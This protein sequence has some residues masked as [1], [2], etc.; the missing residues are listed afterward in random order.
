MVTENQYLFKKTKIIC[1]IG[2]SS[3][4][5]RTILSMIQK[6]MNVAR[7]NASH[8][9]HP[10]LAQWIKTIRK[11]EKEALVPIPILLDL[12]GPKIRMGEMEDGKPVGLHSGQE[13]VITTETV[14]GNEKRISTTYKSLPK[15]VNPGDILFLNDGLVRLKVKEKTSKEIHAVIE[16]GGVIS[17]FKGINIPGG[18]FKGNRLTKKDKKDI[19]FALDYQIDFLAISF[20]EKASDIQLVKKQMGSA[21]NPPLLIAKIE[22]SLALKNLDK[23]LSVSDGVMIARGDLGVEIRLERVPLTQKEI[24]KKSLLEKRFS[25][26]ATQMLESMT[27]GPQPTR[28][29][30][31]DVANSILDHTDGIMLSG[32]TAMGKN[33][34][35]AVNFMSKIAL[36]IEENE[37]KNPLASDRIKGTILSS[38]D[39]ITWS[40]VEAA[41]N[42]NLEKIVVFTETGKSAR[43]LSL[44]RPR[45]Q[46]FAFTPYDN[47]LHQLQI[48]HGVFAQKI[49]KAHSLEQLL[50]TMENLGLKKQF[51][52]KNETV[53]VIA[54]PPGK[55]GGTNLVKIHEIGI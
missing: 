6:G 21:N 40:A 23:I 36:E 43:S 28:A 29:E 20:V 5:D 49:S 54:G 13:L 45:Q 14:L 35:E 15:M 51:W 11:A 16:T 30:V 19:Q 41:D 12:Q 32:E 3:S 18:A 26:V 47:V 42:L 55:S 9:D 27:H 17:N 8:A 4:D 44:R 2:P 53:I 1:T 33:P 10:T 48:L 37:F 39:A 31:S 46:I 7:L 38:T 34:V 24:I 52:K 50:K 22:R 25:I